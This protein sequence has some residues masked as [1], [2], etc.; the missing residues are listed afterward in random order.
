MF[1]FLALVTNKN[2]WK[3]HSLIIK[4][5]LKIYGIKVGKSFYCEGVPLLKIRGKSSNIIIKDNVSFLGDVDLRNR[6]NGK[7]ILN[8]NVTLEG[9][10]RLVSA[11]DGTINIGNNTVIGAYSVLNGGDDI[12]IG[13]YCALSTRVCINSNEHTFTKDKYI[14]IQGFIHKPVVIENDVLIGVNVAINKGVIIA[15]GSVIGANTVVTNNTEEY[16]INAGVPNKKIGER[17]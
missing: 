16:S 17:K 6:E 15:K 14:R 10:V 11:R 8:N 9:N 2:Y 4:L 1:K 5:I 3:L 13:E 12:L 7:I